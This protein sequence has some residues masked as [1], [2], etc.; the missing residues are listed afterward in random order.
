MSNTLSIFIGV[1]Q[2]RSQTV[3]YILPYLVVYLF[4]SSARGIF[5]HNLEKRTRS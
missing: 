2:L 5:K 4:M 3:Q 1:T